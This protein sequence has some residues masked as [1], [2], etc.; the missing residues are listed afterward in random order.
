MSTE[1]GS[2]S[3]SLTLDMSE[4]QAGMTEAR[5]LAADLATTLQQIFSGGFNSQTMLTAL[6]E[7]IENIKLLRAELVE[8]KALQES[9]SSADMFAA[10]RTH[11]ASLPGEIAS[12]R[13]EITNLSTALYSL[14]DDVELVVSNLSTQ[15]GSVF[16]P[17]QTAFANLNTSLGG[18]S[19][20]A[21]TFSTTLA[22]VNSAGITID[23]STALSQLQQMEAAV[24][25]ITTGMSV[26]TT[27]DFSTGAIAPGSSGSLDGTFATVLQSAR[28]ISAVL[29]QCRITLQ[30]CAN[31]TINWNLELQN[32]ANTVAGIQGRLSSVSGSFTGMVHRAGALPTAVRSTTTQANKLSKSLQTVKGH[33]VSIKGI[34]GGIIVSQSF[35]RLLDIMQR[36]V[37]GAKEFST[38]MQDA[39]VSFKYLMG[40]NSEVSSGS[41]LNAMTNIAQ[42]S[43]MDTSALVS[44]TRQLMAM[45]FTAKATVPTLNILV[46]TA[47]AVGGSA[48]DM[49]D[50]IQHITLAFGQMIAAGKVSAQELRQL[51]NAGLPIY[52]LLSEGLGITM[53]EAKNIGKLNVDSATA[54]FAVLQ[55]LQKRYAGAAKDLSRTVA[56]SLEVIR[57]SLEVT[58]ARA[59]TPYFLAVNTFLNKLADRFVAFSKIT[60]AYGIGGLFQAIFPPKMWPYL[61]QCLA[62]LYQI[63]M[64]LLDIARISSTVFGNT[65][66]YAVK[67]GAY[68]LPVIGN[69][70]R[71]ITTLVRA[72]YATYAPLRT[73]LSLIQLLVIA[74]AVARGIVILAK[75]LWLLTG[76]G[77]ITK[78]IISLVGAIRLLWATNPIIVILLGI[79]SAFLAIVASSEKA[80]AAILGFFGKTRDAISDFT[81][82]L[83][84]GI[85]PDDIAMPEFELPEMDDFSTGIEDMV[86]DLDDLSDAE[87]KASKKAKK[88]KDNIQSFDEVYRIGDDDDDNGDKD[89][90]TDSL[91]DKLKGLGNLDYSD[92]FNWTGDWATD[93]AQLTAGLDDF[94]TDLGD[95]LDKVFALFDNLANAFTGGDGLSGWQNLA[96]LISTILALFG[97]FELAGVFQIVEGLKKIVTA[98]RSI[99]DEGWNFSNIMTLID[100]LGDVLIGFGLLT[101]QWKLLGIG[102]FIQ[103]LHDVIDGIKKISTEGINVDNVLEVIGGIGKIIAGIGLLKGSTKLAGI[104]LM[105]DG[106]SKVIKELAENWDVIR[107]GDW[108]GVNK[109][110]LVL[111]VIE[112]IA[113]LL[114]AL[115]VLSG[116]RGVSAAAGAGAVVTGAGD[117]A[118]GVST[119]LQTSVN[120]TMV[121]LAKNIGMALIVIAE[122]CAG[123]IMIVSTIW[124]LGTLLQKVADAWEPLKDHCVAALAG[125]GVGIAL[126]AAMGV[127]LSSLGQLGKKLIVGVAL[128]AAI[129]A[130]ICV[131]LD[132]FIANII[133]IGKLFQKVATAWEPLKD[134][135]TVA[136]AAL[137]VS[138]ALLTAIGAAC[139]ALGS[140]GTTLLINIAIGAAILAEIAV[141]TDLFI[142]NVILIG[143]LLQKVVEVWEPV[144]ENG[145]FALAAILTSTTIMAAIGTVCGTLGSVGAALLITMGIGAAVLA[146]IAIIADLFIANIILLGYELALVVTAWTPVINN[147]QTALIAIGCAATL[148]AAIG[149]VCGLLGTVGADLIIAIALGAAVLAEIAIATDLFIAQIWLMGVLLQN[150]IAAWEPVIANADTCATAIAQGTAMLIGVGAACGALGVA[151][152]ASSGL[153]P[154]AIALGTLMLIEMQGAVA[155]L[156][157]SITDIANQLANELYPAL[158]N[159]NGVLPTI[160]EYMQN[161]VNFMADFATATA[162]YTTSLG[163]LTWD[164]LVTGFIDFFNF[165]DS[166]FDSIINDLNDMYADLCDLN[167]ALEDANAELEE[168]IELLTSYNSFMSRMQLL[169]KDNGTYSLQIGM[170]TNLQQV[171]EKLVT[172]LIA[173]INT[174]KPQA[175]TAAQQLGT[176]TVTA[177][178]TIITSNTSSIRQLANNLGAQ[179][180]QGMQSGISS[181][182][183]AVQSAVTNCVL[184]VRSTL[185]GQ[186]SPS[187]WMQ[188]GQYICQ[189]ISQGISANAPAVIAQ[190]NSLAQQ[191]RDIIQSALRM[192]SPSRVM[193]DM[194]E[195]I[196]AGLVI[197]MQTGTKG[198]V[199]AAQDV[200]DS[201]TNAI[202]TAET[203]TIT[204]DAAATNTLDS[205]QVWG[206]AFVGIMQHI[207]SQITN[208]FDELNSRLNALNTGKG[209]EAKISTIRTVEQVATPQTNTT[210]T[211]KTVASLDDDTITRLTGLTADRMYEYL[212]P[213]FASISTEDQNRTPLYVGTLIADDVGLRE[214][215][216]K[217]NIIR[218]AEGRRS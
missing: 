45:G 124:L 88:L 40:A 112:F 106:L 138:I 180:M 161:F 113:G 89:D 10:M 78:M 211:Q 168:C 175:Q 63:G 210:G 129:L 20:A 143:V 134:N 135:C 186:C 79:A 76:I 21:T 158:E 132:L 23:F 34:I 114:L 93:W 100:G 43:P 204:I 149:V 217:L 30:E 74:V 176:T 131:A 196:D 85:D 98:V 118:A 18:L 165:G 29:D 110:N 209:I 47:A 68:V 207:I 4:F 103:G 48:A 130:E 108:S 163:D 170:F 109:V 91:F 90:P 139:A 99:L 125:L 150:V 184:S 61:R 36:L 17:L 77:A 166:P 182:N 107:K 46:D 195:N 27:M 53:K 202:D 5:T 75:A 66:S 24:N 183:G 171:G 28:D 153:L 9:M 3:A 56:G 123:L 167:A 144:T 187:N 42:K 152:V 8:L 160:T 32:V 178:K 173:G 119:A 148:M 145:Q 92:L 154:L 86:D 212:A 201:L 82:V 194:G 101:R 162:S 38:A 25:N 197:G 190:A 70:A 54:V 126:L 198:V 95:G 199:Q 120:P 19:T 67:I 116:L 127:L 71:T 142:A 141:I 72:L 97:Q 200:A 14:N 64:A 185:Q 174:K 140:V 205:L 122:V 121:R 49:S 11:T 84:I 50:K 157:T 81:Q 94:T 69:L 1:V 22:A 206:D 87:D 13:S 156:I 177:L 151:T 96:D 128:G 216:R 15:L 193:I 105:L 16:A 214:L 208:M 117:A 41:V 12:I 104:G 55:Q 60:Q 73:F 59:W 191:I 52:E 133:L 181:G 39:A 189:G 83:D 137:V 159:V 213:L 172:G 111:G 33:A 179:M 2:L 115:G 188:F 51:Y 7:I 147:S 62:G 164:S 203:P 26:W 218:I 58:L 44:A 169:S 35:Y 192:H 146:E 136:L 31:V 6:Q 102:L 57:E 65:L 155:A 80:K 215:E 37:Q